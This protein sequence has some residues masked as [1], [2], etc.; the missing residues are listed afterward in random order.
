MIFA[1]LVCLA[2]VLIVSPLD[3]AIQHSL[4]RVVGP[5]PNSG[6]LDEPSY[7]RTTVSYIVE[8]TRVEAW[9]YLPKG[10]SSPP[11]VIMAHGLG[12]QRDMGLHPYAH[13]FASSGIAV[14]VF[15]YRG[16]G[17]SDGEP[18]HWVSPIRHIMDWVHAVHWVKVNTTRVSA[19]MLFWIPYEV[20]LDLS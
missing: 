4:S 9:L 6:D 1:G 18:R 19:S 15:D 7:Q 10:V 5:T 20:D 8:G 11:V 13:E 14:L 2:A 17:G 12:G 3:P 16:F